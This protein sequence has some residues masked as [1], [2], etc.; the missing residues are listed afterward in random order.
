M[1][2][3]GGYVVLAFFCGQ[4]VAWFGESGLGTILAI[5][6]IE[7]LSAWDLPK[8]MLVVSI[9]LLTALLNLFIGSASAKWFLLAPVFV[10]LFLGLGVSPELTQAAYRVGDSTTNII[11]PLNPYLVIVIVFMR[12]YQKDAGIGS[13]LSL[14]L[15]YTIVLL[16]G[17]IAMLLVWMAFGLSLGPDTGPLFVEPMTAG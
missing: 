8:P 16:V 10:P 5:R 14:M 3:M 11:A 17:W 6:G 4:F 12:R 1:A 9:I 15:P 13:V 2:S 7:V